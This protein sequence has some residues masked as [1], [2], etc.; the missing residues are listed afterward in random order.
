MNRPHPGAGANVHGGIREFPSEGRHDGR[1]IDDAFFGDMDRADARNVRLDLFCLGGR[2]EPQ[3]RQA[4]CGAAIEKRLETRQFVFAGGYDEL[5][6]DLMGNPM[7][8]TK[9]SHCT[10]ARY[11]ESRLGG[12]RLV[13]K[14]C[15]KNAGIMCTLMLAEGRLFFEK[16]EASVRQQSTKRVGGAKPD[17]AAAYDDDACGAGR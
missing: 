6:H 1:I 7:T 10:D 9:G 3:T 16:R 15:V 2:K 5:P 4:I 11:G 12:S 14:T 8:T 17:E 13:V